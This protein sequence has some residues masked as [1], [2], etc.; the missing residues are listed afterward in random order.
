MD[1]AKAPSRECYVVAPQL[2]IKAIIVQHL[3]LNLLLWRAMFRQTLVFWRVLLMQMKIK[4]S[5][6]ICI[7]PS[8]WNQRVLEFVTQMS[9]LFLAVLKR[10]NYSHA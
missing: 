2:T 5:Q 3:I 10:Y 6:T 9:D 4:Q 8:Q 7:P 1:A